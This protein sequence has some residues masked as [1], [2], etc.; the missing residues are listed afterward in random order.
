MKLPGNSSKIQALWCSWI[1]ERAKHEW[2][3]LCSSYIGLARG[4]LGEQRLLRI[5]ALTS[6]INELFD[7]LHRHLCASVLQRKIFT[8]P[9]HRDVQLT[10]E[11]VKMMISS[12]EFCSRSGGVLLVAPEHR[13]SLQLKWHELR[14]QGEHA[15]CELLD[16]FFAL[17]SRD[18]LDESDEVL[19]H[20]YQLIY[21]VAS[22]IPLPEGHERV[23]GGND[24]VPGFAQ[25]P[26]AARPFD[27]RKLGD[28]TRR[29][30]K[31]FT[32]FAWCQGRSSRRS[33]YKCEFESWRSWWKILHTISPGWGN[34][35]MTWLSSC[36][37]QVLRQMR[38][39]Y[40]NA[41]PKKRIALLWCWPCE[42]SWHVRS[43]SIA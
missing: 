30:A 18:C 23:D 39:F 5:T 35:E 13:L 2:F 26:E 25:L 38:P 8:L 31:P 41:F 14:L 37:W 1:W 15:L 17:P 7:F 9:F 24:V 29:L 33:C 21:A 10:E 3:Y 34:I 20:K 11:D 19:R 32:W 12:M 6:L 22:P 43:W 27:T 36:S 40:L 16:Q 42:D 28:G 4:E